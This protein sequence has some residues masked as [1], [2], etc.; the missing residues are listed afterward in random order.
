MSKIN[1]I[2]IGNDQINEFLHKDIGKRVNLRTKFL[3]L[4]QFSI[5]LSS[6]IPIVDSIKILIDQRE[7]KSL[8]KSLERVVEN[9]EN[10][11]GVSESFS[12]DKNFD[13]FFIAMLKLGESSG[14]LDKVMYDLSRYYE[15]S[16]NMKSKLT[17]A[18]TYPIILS[19]VGMVMMIFLV[20]TVVPSF[21]FIFNDS[22]IAI[23][24]P[25]RIII[26]L[27]EIINDYWRLILLALILVGLAL[28][29]AYKKTKFGYYVD[30]FNT[31][32]RIYGT[33][34]KIIKTSKIARTLY[35]TQK[36]S[37]TILDGLA[38]IYSGMTNRYY[39]GELLEII[40]KIE[41]GSQSIDEA[42]NQ[43]SITPVVFNSM[44]KIA[45]N[46]GDFD[47]V[48]N[49]ISNFYDKEV[50]YAIK[51]FVSIFEPM[52]ILVMGFLVGFIVIS[53]TIPMFEMINSF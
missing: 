33:Y 7:L 23:P 46:T 8:R 48:L 36:N 35:V 25:T 4:R 5:L 22:D 9:L 32:N 10:G 37:M 31:N 11:F 28:F 40:E 43:S 2:K 13:P 3:F 15:I 44:L 53:I 24:L 47:E 42:F 17:N 16:Y 14:K 18:L 50:E 27:S 26:K 29:I 20:K 51:G 19:L 21:I 49:K 41:T 1:Q 6:K 45:E 38:I 52:I 30:K 12:N 39:R 34:N